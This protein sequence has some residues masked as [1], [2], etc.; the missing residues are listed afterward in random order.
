MSF[1]VCSRE[2]GKSTRTT[3]TALAESVAATAATVSDMRIVTEQGLQTVQEGVREGV[4]QLKADVVSTATA[5]AD[6]IHDLDVNVRDTI[7]TFSDADRNYLLEAIRREVAPALNVLAEEV[8]SLR[9]QAPA[10]G[11]HVDIAG[12]LAQ[13]QQRL[14]D[15]VSAQLS[16]VALVHSATAAAVQRI[17]EEVQRLHLELSAFGNSQEPALPARIEAPTEPQTDY[18]DT[19][20]AASE[21]SESSLSSGQV[22]LHS[23]PSYRTDT[24][25]AYVAISLARSNT[26]SRATSGTAYSGSSRSVGSASLADALSRRVT[27]EGTGVLQA[28]SYGASAG[29]IATGASGE[30][31]GARAHML[32]PLEELPQLTEVDIAELSMGEVILTEDLSSG[33]LVQLLPLTHT[34]AGV[35]AYGHTRS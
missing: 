1:C 20:S 17:E 18:A 10:P 19:S 15:E 27:P 26:T 7:T 28:P 6:G 30:Y 5:L 3:V 8:S 31:S 33:E 29:G 35:I 12:P 23:M 32:H 2:E 21:T 22:P 9:D 13:L 24:S 34:H 25:T 4:E 16:P 14:C 11:Q